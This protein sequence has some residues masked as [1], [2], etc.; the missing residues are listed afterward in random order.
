[1]R[2]GEC[3]GSWWGNRTEGLGCLRIFGP[4]RDEVS[5]QWIKQRNEE[6]NDMYC[7]P[8]VL[9][10]IKS[11]IRWVGHVAG[12]REKRGVYRV[13]VWKRERTNHLGDLSAEEK[14]ILRWIFRKWDLGVWTGSS[15]FRIG[16]GG[17]LL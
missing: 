17:G 9:R 15:W 11:R 5:A 16:T 2:R 1:M 3:I 10:L 7:S 4:N 8:N 12:V 6:P 13:L 14:I